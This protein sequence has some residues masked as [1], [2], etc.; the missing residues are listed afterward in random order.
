MANVNAGVV[1][2]IWSATPI[3]QA[4]IDY[5]AFSESLKYNHWIGMLMIII[6]SVLLGLQKEIY[7]AING[8]D[9]AGTKVADV[10]EKALPTW[11]PVL[12]GIF[13]PVSFSFTTVI[14]KLVT[15]EKFGINF[16]GDKLS[17]TSLFCI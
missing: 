10:S 3:F 14:T 6:C 9:K 4:I 7:S 5:F 16:D 1:T 11:V 2:V 15:Q 13:S 8:H 12:F 17:V